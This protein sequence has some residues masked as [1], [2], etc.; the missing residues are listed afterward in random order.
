ML[1]D[2]ISIFSLYVQKVYWVPSLSQ[3]Q[4]QALVQV[5]ARSQFVQIYSVSA[6]MISNLREYEVRITVFAFNSEDII[7]STS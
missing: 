2:V 5:Q 4:K 6:D 3:N 7:V 1:R